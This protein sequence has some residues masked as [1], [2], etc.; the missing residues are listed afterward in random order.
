VCAATDAC[1]ALREW[2]WTGRRALRARAGM[3]T[4]ME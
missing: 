4:D 3:D 1:A 2:V